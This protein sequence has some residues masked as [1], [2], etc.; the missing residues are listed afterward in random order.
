[1]IDRLQ[2]R[3]IRP[4]GSIRRRWSSGRPA[5]GR[6]QEGATASAT[7]QSSRST[8]KKNRQFGPT[9][10]DLNPGVLHDL[11][12]KKTGKMLTTLYAIEPLV[13]EDRRQKLEDL[14]TDLVIVLAD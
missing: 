3:A 9:G 7:S 14:A 11:T 1:M 5:E 6:E 4:V 13:P 12:G 2:K 8:G 10:F